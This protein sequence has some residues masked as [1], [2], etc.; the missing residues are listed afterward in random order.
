[1]RPM[2]VLGALLLIVATI[3]YV[4]TVANLATMHDSDPAGNALSRVYA[5]FMLIVLW[6]LLAALLV[7]ASLRGAMPRWAPLAA[8]VLLP[9]SGAA[10]LA[11]AQLLA[12]PFYT[13][14]WPIIIPALAPLAII[15]YAL[16]VYL[17]SIH[18]AVPATA[19]SWA[20]WS[21]VM[22]LSLAPWPAVAYRKRHGETD[23]A[24]A[25]A[26][27]KADEPRRIE[28]ERQR[29]LEAFHQLTS[30]SELEQWLEFR[31]PGNELREQALEGI[32]RLPRRQADAELMI[33]RRLDYFWD[34]VPNL[35]LVASPAICEGAR[36]FLRE[37]VTDIRPLH[38]SDPPSFA[39][40]VERVEPY[41]PT[42]Q[43]LVDH[44]CDCDAELAA[45]EATVRVYPDSPERGR[46][47]SALTRIR[48][49][50]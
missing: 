30:E 37:R 10:A 27:R 26:A 1:M 9:A 3:L 40:M 6:I 48:Q 42:M 32:R 18:K 22:L 28:E 46:F 8:V 33:A 50:R 4:G 5:V 14:R 17:P 20:V 11:A 13:A 2:T 44:H 16:W 43:W 34:D 35:D 49:P 12:D 25:E 31:A 36:A 38:P 24:R 15:A 19:A 41:L 45:L 7:I 47:L 39:F 23:R 21:M 29:N